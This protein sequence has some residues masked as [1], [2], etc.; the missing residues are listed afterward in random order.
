MIKNIIFDFGN[1]IG[2]FDYSLSNYMG[3][4]SEDVRN[5]LI[6][7][8]IYSDEWEGKGMIDLGEITLEEAA[9]RITPRAQG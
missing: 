8:V 1:I 6:K 9:D 5:F 3:K 4:Y 7:N 2:K